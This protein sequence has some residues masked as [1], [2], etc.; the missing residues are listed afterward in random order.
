MRVYRKHN[1]DQGTRVDVHYDHEADTYR[2]E[3]WDMEADPVQQVGHVC[4]KAHAE[5]MAVAAQVVA[6]KPLPGDTVAV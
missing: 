4:R 3:L 1:D 2:V 5:A 6:G